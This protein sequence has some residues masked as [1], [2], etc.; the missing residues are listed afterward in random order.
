VKGLAEVL[1]IPIVSLS[2]LE[3]L[4]ASSQQKSRVLAVLDAGRNEC[5][6]GEYDARAARPALVREFLCSREELLKL[7]TSK[8]FPMVTCE[9]NLVRFL[10]EQ[11]ISIRQVPRPDSAFAVQ[12]GYRRLLAGETADVETLDANYIRRSDAEIFSKPR[13]DEQKRPS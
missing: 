9:E 11:D 3:L 12:C 1:Q 2:L 5:Y 10:Q 6:C 8:D 7:R 4:A 13:L